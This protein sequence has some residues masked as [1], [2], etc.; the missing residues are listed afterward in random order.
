MAHRIFLLTIRS[1]DLVVVFLKAGQVQKLV[2][3]LSRQHAR[4][5][6][7]HISVLRDPRKTA[8]V[9]GLI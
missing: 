2:A 7:P 1:M 9:H 8:F 6:P 5:S 3:F 4:S